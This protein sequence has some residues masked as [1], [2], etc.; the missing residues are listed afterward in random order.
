MIDIL[1]YKF[2]KKTLGYFATTAFAVWAMW[3]FD[4]LPRIFPSAFKSKMALKKPPMDDFEEDDD[5]LNIPLPSTYAEEPTSLPDTQG[6]PVYTKPSRNAAYNLKTQGVAGGTESNYI[7]QLHRG[8]GHDEL[9]NG[10]ATTTGTIEWQ[11][12]A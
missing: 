10:T 6:K 7:K 5:D 4:V 12:Y 11:G 8:G 3:Y 2:S 1:G 9:R